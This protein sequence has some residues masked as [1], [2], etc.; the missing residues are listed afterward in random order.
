LAFS[1]PN[2]I[3]PIIAINKINDANSKG[4]IY[5]VKSTV[6]RALTLSFGK[7]CLKLENLELI[8]R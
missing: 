5:F 1:L 3:A 7:G 2:I 6:P 4:A 8:T